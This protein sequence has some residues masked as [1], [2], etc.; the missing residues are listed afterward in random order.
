MTSKVAE[1]QQIEDFAKKSGVALPVAIARKLLDY[2]DLLYRWNAS[3]G[4]T[5]I[6]REDAVRLHLVDSLWALKWVQ[7]TSALADLGTGAGLPGIP[8]GLVR[9]DM[10]VDLVETK[11]RKCSFL[12][13]A[14][15]ELELK[16]CEV[17]EADAR[18]LTT[19]MAPPETVIARAFMQPQQMLDLAVTVALR[20]VVLMVGPTV[21]PSRLRVPPSWGVAGETEY[22]LFAGNERH[23]ILCFEIESP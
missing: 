7:N 15:R 6:P 2:L 17:V 16:N 12:R 10:H 21:D 1:Q 3:A 8:L 14:V 22:Q 19:A 11:R 9:P 20:S 18:V 13:E 4:L 23:R 5:R